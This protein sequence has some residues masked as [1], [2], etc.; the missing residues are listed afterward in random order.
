MKPPPTGVMVT[1]VSV[2]GGGV[3]AVGGESTTPRVHVLITTQPITT[4]IDLDNTPQ[5]VANG[6]PGPTPA[7]QRAIL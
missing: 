4:V 6:A 3:G 5:P 7:V 1:E 2:G